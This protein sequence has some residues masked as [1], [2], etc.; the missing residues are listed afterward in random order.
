MV[1]LMTN[2]SHLCKE[3]SVRMHQYLKNQRYKAEG[4]QQLKRQLRTVQLL[5]R[6]ALN[7]VHP[8]KVLA[9]R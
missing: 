8:P 2:L 7:Q 1:N 4:L 3:H 5:A 6:L 9:R